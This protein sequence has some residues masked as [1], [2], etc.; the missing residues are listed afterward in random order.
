MAPHRRLLPPA[1]T[2]AV[3]E[4]SRCQYSFSFFFLGIFLGFG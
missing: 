4:G 2:G 1:Y 3:A